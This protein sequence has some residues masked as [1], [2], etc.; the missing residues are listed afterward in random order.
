MADYVHIDKGVLIQNS[1]E[2]VEA[3]ERCYT[4][5]RKQRIAGHTDKAKKVSSVPLVKAALESDIQVRQHVHLAVVFALAFQIP[6]HSAESGEVTAGALKGR[7]QYAN[8]YCMY[9]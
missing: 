8:P 4:K 1:V 7:V 6:P 5:Q 9:P 3:V 2:Y